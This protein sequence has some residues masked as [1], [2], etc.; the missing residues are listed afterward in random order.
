MQY[1]K[2]ADNK[3]YFIRKV[4]NVDTWV[5]IDEINKDDLFKLLNAAM[6]NDFAMDDYTEQ[7]LQNKAHFIIYK[8]LHSKLQDLIVNKNRFKDDSDNLYKDAYDKYKRSD[9]ITSDDE[10]NGIN[11]I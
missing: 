3:A 8:H 9:N 2:V 1:L 7:S 6:E 4:E 5:L 10:L 11:I